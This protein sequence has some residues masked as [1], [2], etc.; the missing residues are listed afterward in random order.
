MSLLRTPTLEQSEASLLS[1]LQDLHGG[2]THDPRL[3][4]AT[5]PSHPTPPWLPGAVLF[6]QILALPPSLNLSKTPTQ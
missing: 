3:T 6:P 1:G 5:L 2:D 4:P